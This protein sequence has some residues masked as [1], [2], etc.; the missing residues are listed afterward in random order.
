MTSLD[1]A[2]YNKANLKIQEY[3]YFLQNEGPIS[4]KEKLKVAAFGSSAK[5]T[6]KEKKRLKKADRQ[7]KRKEAERVKEDQKK[8]RKEAE[9]KKDIDKAQR[10]ADKDRAS[11]MESA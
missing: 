7:E 4:T 5:L 6:G 10:A 11:G 8:A 2:N 9:S 3:L 1:K